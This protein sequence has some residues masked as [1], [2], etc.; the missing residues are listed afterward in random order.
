MIRNSLD[1]PVISG[2]EMTHIVCMKE[3]YMV[4]QSGHRENLAVDTKV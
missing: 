2:E 1:R 4:L 3:L